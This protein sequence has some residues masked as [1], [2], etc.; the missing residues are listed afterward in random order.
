MPWVPSSSTTHVDDSNK[1][2]E[3]DEIGEASMDVEQQDHTIITGTNIST[4][5]LHHAVGGGITAPA[6]PSEGFHQWQQQQQQHCLLPQFPQNTSTPI[7]FTW[8]R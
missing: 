5:N 8:T 2:E 7:T 6:T 1:E 4:S 3:A